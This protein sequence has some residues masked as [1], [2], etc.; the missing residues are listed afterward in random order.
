M[1]LLRVR[2]AAD[3]CGMHPRTLW[4]RIKSGQLPAWGSPRRVRISDVL[5]RYDPE[6][7]SRE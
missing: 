4:R 5:V 1:E 2:D 3:L 6:A 7:P